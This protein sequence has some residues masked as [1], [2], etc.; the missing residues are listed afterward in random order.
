MV[1]PNFTY[2]FQSFDSSIKKLLQLFTIKRIYVYQ[3]HSLNLLFHTE[4]RGRLSSLQQILLQQQRIRPMHMS[5]L[6][7]IQSIFHH[8]N[9]AKEF[10]EKSGVQLAK[11]VA[12][13]CQRKPMP[14]FTHPVTML[15]PNVKYCTKVN[16]NTLR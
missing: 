16:E 12:S 11:G 4:N 3:T 2:H 10:Q 6:I 7:S 15:H 1:L 5:G 9:F 13:Y 8:Q 14:R